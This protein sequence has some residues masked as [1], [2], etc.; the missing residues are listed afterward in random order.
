MFS[1]REHIS[2]IKKIFSINFDAFVVQVIVIITIRDRLEAENVSI[3]LA[4]FLIQ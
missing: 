3:F 2:Q 4:T 1:I